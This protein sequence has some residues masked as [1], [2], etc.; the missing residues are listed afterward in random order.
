MQKDPFNI[1]IL[2]P[3]KFIESRGCLPVTSYSMF[4][5]ST[6]KFHQDGLYSELIFGQVGSSARLVNRGY[7]S[8]RTKIITPHL[9]KQILTLKKTLL[10]PII[11]G[12]SYA[13]FDEE[14]KM[15]VKTTPDDPKG[16]TGYSFFLSKIKD[17]QFVDTGSVTT[18][19]KI[20]LLEKYKDQLFM[21][22]MIVIAAGLR[23]V[24]IKNGR[25]TSED[26]NK[27]YLH[28][29]SL[30]NAMPEFET[31]DPI[32]DSIRYQIQMK[33][34][35]IYD[36]LR[37]VM[38]DKKGFGQGRY[39][40]RDVAYSNR[41][42]ITGTVI[43]DMETPDNN[44]MPSIDDMIVPLFQGIKGAAPAVA[45]QLKN[46]F[47]EYVSDQTSTAYLIDPDTYQLVV[48]EV[49]PDELRKYTSIDGMHK[50]IN[51]FRDAN[52][53]FLPVTITATG[54]SGQTKPY[55]VSLVYDTDDT[56]RYF[57][58]K[59]EFK[60]A[61]AKRSR[62]RTDFSKLFVIDKLGLNS[63]DFFIEGSGACYSYGLDFNPVDIDLVLR[64][65]VF[66][67]LSKITGA[68]FDEF[69]DFEIMV[70][71]TE[72]H[73]KMKVYGIKTDEDF[74]NL[75]KNSCITIGNY[76][77]IS[78]EVML[79]RY[80][81]INRIKDRRKIKE[82]QSIVLDDEK[83][84]PLTYAELIYI[85]GHACLH[86]RYCAGVRYPVNCIQSL[87][88][89]RVHLM[90]TT[91]SRRVTLRT[92]DTDEPYVEFPEYPQIGS[93]VRVSM[94][95]HPSALELFNGDHDG[96]T[97]S[98]HIFLSDEANQEAK[99]FMKSTS[100]MLNGNGDLLYGVT[101]S[102]AGHIDIALAYLTY[103]KLSK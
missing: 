54:P 25:P 13:Y 28:L 61:F 79:E 49:D 52:V 44:T 45:H 63:S 5:P 51:D 91:P 24:K 72:V 53:H 88:I 4:E 50:I 69:G 37:N 48:C 35:E 58:N 80:K 83:I 32:Y 100:S 96:D 57:R 38:D 56:V 60:E 7:I 22:K 26:I 31:E 101:S 42:V 81:K 99:D 103:H 46:W 65:S 62:Y 67:R 2:D 14:T 102:K 90:S 10:T 93:P 1:R 18:K 19:N 85:S 66:D 70:D 89:F 74:D 76:R 36:Y 68:K 47:A 75:Y 97:M 3:D 23:D 21:N 9:F 17:V 12:T 8:L 55:L 43:S 20:D 77:F 95:A 86:E 41:N 94:S 87:N 15:F 27:L 98:L 64:P 92:K 39:S 78:P 84:R 34:V 29:L 6:S 71:D 59:D 30:A 33:V 82:L 11:E 40:S 16:N 73:C